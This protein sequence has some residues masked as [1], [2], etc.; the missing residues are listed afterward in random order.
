[1]KNN[2]PC[3]LIVDD[4]DSVR[5][6]LD[7]SLKKLPGITL[8]FACDG[9]EAIGLLEKHGNEVCVLIT[10][11]DMPHMTGD[12]LIAR[13]KEKFPKI[14]SMLTSGSLN[15]EN[16]NE[17]EGLYKPDIFIAKPF[18]L[19]AIKTLTTDLIKRFKAEHGHVE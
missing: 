3:V 5:H 7:L 17:M 14:K 6:I 12:E 4:N 19:E 13:T 15:Q 18:Q 1:M 2:A 8:L 11:H 10:D 9:L 16:I